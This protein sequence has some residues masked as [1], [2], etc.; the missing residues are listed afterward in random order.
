M[1]DKGHRTEGFIGITVSF[2]TV[3]LQ[4][5]MERACAESSCWTCVRL[6]RPGWARYT[7]E[8]EH[9]QQKIQHKMGSITLELFGAD[10]HRI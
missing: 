1:K 2:T 5:S 8:L 4:H 6:A 3:E 10:L 9:R 7:Q